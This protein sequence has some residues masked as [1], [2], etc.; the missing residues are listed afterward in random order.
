MALY[1]GVDTSNYASSVALYDSDINR[2]VMKRRLLP[3]PEGM[4][5]LRQ[6]DA[7]FA[8]VKQLSSVVREMMV[9]AGPL[10]QNLS[11]VGVSIAPR[12]AKGSYMPC[13]LVGKMAA[14][15]IAAL[16]SVPVFEFS[17]QEG[18]ITAALYSSHAMHLIEREFFAFHVSG[19]TTEA[20]LVHPNHA[21]V[22]QAECVAKTLDL[23][24]GQLIDRVGHI[25]GY[26][27]P[28][29][30]ELEQAASQWKLP[31]KVHAT[32]KGSDICL[33]GVQNQ[34]EKLLREGKPAPLIARFCLESVGAALEAMLKTLLAQHGNLPIV[35]AGGVMS[36][37]LI[38][39]KLS[40]LADCHFAEPVFSADNAAGIAILASLKGR[41]NERNQLCNSLPNQ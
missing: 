18:H 30:P 20:V 29:G 36:N 5:G 15:S 25:L 34:C 14:E 38:K 40:A 39:D 10:A 2:V 12:R 6:S 13:F 41:E 22:F 28:A 16:L 32:Q 9:E 33:S 3:V 19:G 1:L 4:V 27:F 31:I 11:G 17:H 24:A 7:V 23:N 21:H 35:F 37:Q 8:H 26:T